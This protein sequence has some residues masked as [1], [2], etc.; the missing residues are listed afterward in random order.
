M[1][2]KKNFSDYIV[3]LVVI[4][5]TIVLLG[6]L[7]FALSGRQLKKSNRTVQIDYVDV[8]GI[9]LASDLRYAG[10]PAGRVTGIRFL[11]PEERAQAPEGQKANAVRVTVTV[12]DGVPPFPSDVTASI[13]SD[14]L[15]SDKF[16]TLSAG[17]VGVGDLANNAILQGHPG[18]LDSLFQNAGPVVAHLDETLTELKNGV[19]DVMPKLSGVLVAAHNTVDVAQNFLKN[20]DSLIGKDGNLRLTIDQL[21]EAVVKL[22]AV[23]GNLDDVL[24]NTNGLV[25]NTDKNLNARMQELGV[26]LQNLKVVTTYLKSFSKSVAEKPNRLIFT[27]KS[28]DLESESQILESDQPVPARVQKKK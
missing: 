18:G 28:P 20:A 21:K 5:C 10:A 6:A 25:S 2:L 3:A 24:K 19:K 8:T 9:H 14:T 26:V 11:T 1:T 15:L 4:F 7:T 27:S 16:I 22:K 12:N 17:T 23:E 13:G